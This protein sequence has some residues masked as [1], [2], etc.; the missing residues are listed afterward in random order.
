VQRDILPIVEGTSVNTRYGFVRTDHI[1]FIAAGAFHVAKPSD[2]IP[3]L[4]GRFPIRVELKS[5]N[6]QDFIR[7]LKEPKN[8]LIKQYQALLD[9]EGIKLTFTEDAIEAIASFA[10]QVNESTENIGARRLHTILEKLL[11]DVSFDGPDL[12]K[13]IVKVDAAYV[14][15]QLAEIVKD[16][17]LS[18]YIL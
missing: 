13:K 7:I 16:Q 15:R 12:K 11:E 5:L 6:E 18:R 17:D 2:L 4:Q 9:T 14:R 8:A 3:E 10:A 1:L